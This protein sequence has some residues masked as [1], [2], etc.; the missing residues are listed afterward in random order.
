MTTSHTTVVLS[1]FSAARTCKKNIL[2]LLV[3]VTSEL[4][5]I[6]NSDPLTIQSIWPL[7]ALQLKIAVEPSV[8]FNDAGVLR[9]T[10]YKQV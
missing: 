9:K 2:P 8:A 4:P 6:D 7:V 10:G 3:A 1:Y 5:S